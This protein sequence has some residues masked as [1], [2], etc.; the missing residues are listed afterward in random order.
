[1][2]H[3]VRESP[4]PMSL[5]SS[6]SGRFSWVSV[7]VAVCGRGLW[8]HHSAASAPEVSPV[9]WLVWP[10]RP[11]PLGCTQSA[12][13]SGCSASL[14]PC[15]AAR[16]L[17]L[18]VLQLFPRE[19]AGRVPGLSG[20]ASATPHLAGG[21]HW[22]SGWGRHAEGPRLLR[23][24]LGAPW[25]PFFHTPVCA[26]LMSLSCECRLPPGAQRPFHQ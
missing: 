7:L 20:A 25:L 23:V 15:R 14:P 26:S 11:R 4:V 8:G 3:E 9:V 22:A 1:M 17:P 18:R 2:A 6:A 21:N 19:A 13:G 12:A 24:Q 16:A 10:A 5:G